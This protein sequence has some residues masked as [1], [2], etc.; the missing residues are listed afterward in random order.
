MRSG[1]KGISNLVVVIGIILIG[2]ILIIFSTTFLRE[3][4]KYGLREACLQSVKIAGLSKTLRGG[5]GVTENFNCGTYYYNYDIETK[6][7]MLKD[8]ADE[9]FWCYWQFGSGKVDFLTDYKLNS[10]S[11]CYVCS[12]FTFSDQ[13]RVNYP[14]GITVNELFTYLNNHNVPLG[15][16]TYSEYLIGTK[17]ARYNPDP[18]DKSYLPLDKEYWVVF[19]VVKDGAVESFF[20]DTGTKAKAMVGGGL[21]ASAVLFAIPGVNAVAG[22]VVGGAAIVG[23][24]FGGAKAPDRLAATV[25]MYSKTDLNKMCGEL[26]PFPAYEAS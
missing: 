13:T 15:G 3:T 5:K 16:E 22:V 24:F 12:Q 23:A 2:V 11:K 9:M 26:R 25:S 14:G 17:G 4:G 8:M 19:N 20:V 6:D 7:I 18:A 21:A 10:V 1:K